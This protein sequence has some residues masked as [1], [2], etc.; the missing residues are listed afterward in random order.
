[1]PPLPWEVSKPS[2]GKRITLLPD[3][4]VNRIRRMTNAPLDDVEGTHTKV[5]YR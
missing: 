5:R 3:I 1:M 2:H 4:E